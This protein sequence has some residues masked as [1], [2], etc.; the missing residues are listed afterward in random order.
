MRFAE[1]TKRD[2]SKVLR[3]A[4]LD[5]RCPKCCACYEKCNASLEDMAKVL[6]LPR[7]TTFDTS[8]NM[9]ECASKRAF[10][11]RLPEISQAAASKS[12][13]SYEFSYEPTRKSTFRA[14]LPSIFITCHKM[15]RLPACHGICTLSPLRAALTMRFA[16]NIQHHTSKV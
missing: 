3:H 16:E 4:K 1:N 5:R 2:T 8:W 13:F 12:T 9:L 6:C 14:R 7:K 15:P 11:A 10:R